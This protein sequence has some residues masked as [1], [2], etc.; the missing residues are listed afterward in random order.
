MATV[1][2][3]DN[4]ESA[5][6]TIIKC[7]CMIGAQQSTTSPAYIMLPWYSSFC[8]SKTQ[9]AGVNVVKKGVLVHICNEGERAGQKH[10]TTTI[11]IAN[12]ND[13]KKRTHT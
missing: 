5:F 6:F 1:C 3:Y 12:N 7:F 13:K 11:T 4:A 9:A 10:I 2:V 8:S